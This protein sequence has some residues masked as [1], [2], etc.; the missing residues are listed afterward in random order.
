MAGTPFNRG[1]G[2]LEVFAEGNEFCQKIAYRTGFTKIITT[3]R[4]DD[5]TESEVTAELQG[6]Q[7]EGSLSCAVVSHPGKDSMLPMWGCVLH[8]ER[9]GSCSHT[10]VVVCSRRTQRFQ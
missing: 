3:V 10:L 2:S 9:S 6:W 8:L 1:C 4:N 7:N 5:G